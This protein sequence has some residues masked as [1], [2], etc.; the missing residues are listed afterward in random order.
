LSAADCPSGLLCTSNQCVVPACG[1]PAPYFADDFSSSS[2]VWTQDS[3]WEI[4]AAKAWSGADPK[5]GPTNKDPTTDHSTT[6]DNGIAG[7]VLGGSIP[8]DLMDSMSYLTSPVIDTSGGASPVILEYW[9][10]L[11]IQKSSH[12][13][14]QLEVYN[15]STWTTLWANGVTADVTE[16]AWTKYTYDVTSYRSASFRVRFGFQVVKKNGAQ[17]AGG[18]NIDDVRI[19]N[20]PTCP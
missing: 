17:T 2:G 12:E 20:A 5:V 10:Y 18:W 15:G 1:G 14:A 9:R 19:A 8:I 13:S 3:S 7:T 4:G 11:N 6:S 16:S